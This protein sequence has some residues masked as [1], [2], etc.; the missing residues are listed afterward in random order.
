[1][2]D[3]TSQI[4]A[5]A[6]QPLAL[7]KK[8][9]KIMGELHRLPKNGYNNYHNYPYVMEADVTEALR[10]LM[11][12]YEVVLL[13]RVE[14]FEQQ[15]ELTTVWLH[16]TLLDIDSGETVTARWPG[17]GSDKGDKGI[18]K[19]ITAA[20]KYY[21]LKTFMLSAGDDPEGDTRTD[22]R[23]NRNNGRRDNNSSSSRRND[24]HA[25][26]LPTLPS[27]P[28]QI[29]VAS[30]GI[31]AK[32]GGEKG[33]TLFF[34]GTAVYIATGETFPISGWRTVAQFLNVGLNENKPILVKVEKS[35]RYPEYQV[36]SAEWPKD[37]PNS[38]SLPD[39]SPQAEP[40][41][42]FRQEVARLRQGG[43]TDEKLSNVIKVVA[44]D[45]KFDECSEPVQ[46]VV[47]DILA[48]LP[49]RWANVVDVVSKQTKGKSLMTW[50]AGNIQ[51]FRA[52]L[53]HEFANSH[54]SA[55]PVSNGEV[56]L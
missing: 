19:A 3:P 12:Q 24:S 6:T 53:A 20:T 35:D 51:G 5:P 41:L 15:G 23:A 34:K 10:A 49:D 7:A 33:S 8:I 13:P 45:K 50:D 55:P 22:D 42:A 48:Y 40:K 32:N 26:E 54:P 1:M 47:L 36:K 46:G 25:P 30:G 39:P 52:W 14:G 18:S 28:I 4:L 31:E 17:Q 38:P 44:G 21:L 11:V 37:T 29:R 9:L 56:Q 16:F 43:F 2:T 27:T